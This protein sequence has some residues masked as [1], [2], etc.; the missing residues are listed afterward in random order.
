MGLICVIRLSTLFSI[1]TFVGALGA[2]YL[3]TMID[4]YGARTCVPAGC[5]L[6]ALGVVVLSFAASPALIALGFMLVHSNFN[7][8][9]AFLMHFLAPCRP[10]KLSQ[11]SPI[12]SPHTRRA[13]LASV[14]RFGGC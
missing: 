2:P 6:A 12:C 14:A 3:G 5:V 10:A 9:L 13:T 8:V 4:L 1:G 11:S 7:I